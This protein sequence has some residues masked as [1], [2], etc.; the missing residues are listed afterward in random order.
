LA[1]HDPPLEV[2]FINTKTGFVTEP[3]AKWLIINKRDKANRVEDGTEDNVMLIDDTGNPKDGSRA[4]PS[5]DLVGSTDTQELENKT[6][7]ELVSTKILASDGSSGLQE[8]D[9]SDWVAGTSGRITVTDD[10]DG[11]VTLTVPLKASYGLD[12]DADGLKLKQDANITDASESHII[13][14]PADAP[15]TVD[16]LRDDLVLNAIPDIESALNALGVK[17]NAILDLLL[18]TEIMAGP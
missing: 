7:A 14:D 2:P 8:I 9:L 15:A 10:G 13:T 11:T 6:F 5:G 17:I 4:L 1:L 16:A 12:S 18:A 3:W